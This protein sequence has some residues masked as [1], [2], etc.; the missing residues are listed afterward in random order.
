MKLPRL[1]RRETQ[2][3]KRLSTGSCIA[4]V[5]EDLGLKRARVKSCLYRSY[6]KYGVH[7]AAE[8]IQ[9]FYADS[10]EEDTLP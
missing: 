7:S 3:V 8:L 4:D 6:R 2:V 1:S 10:A 5:V 9:V